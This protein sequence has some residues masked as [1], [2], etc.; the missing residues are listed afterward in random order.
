MDNAKRYFR[1]EKKQL[2]KLD[3]QN[4]MKLSA[5][6]I[7]EEAAIHEGSM[8]HRVLHAHEVV[9]MYETHIGMTGSKLPEYCVVYKDGGKLK[10]TFFNSFGKFFAGNRP[11][12]NRGVFMS[13]VK[14][15][16]GLSNTNASKSKVR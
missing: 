15:L 4:W 9:E 1:Q 3:A 14:R 16:F 7:R 5:R 8:M 10:R 11:S 12:S 13:G 6:E 2:L